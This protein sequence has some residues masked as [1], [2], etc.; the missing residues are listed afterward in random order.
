MNNIEILCKCVEYN[1]LENVQ[2]LLDQG[3]NPTQTAL[4]GRTAIGIACLNKHVEAL[5]IL[6]KACVNYQ[7]SRFDYNTGESE[8]KKWKRHDIDGEHTPEGMDDLQWED[9]IEEPMI[10]TAKVDTVDDEWSVLYRYYARII[11]TTGDLLA[12]AISMRDPHCLDA[13]QESPLHCA[14]SVGSY[15]SVKLLLKHKAPINVT[16]STGYTPLHLAIEQP[17]IVDLLLQYDAN[18]NK[19][20]YVDQMAPIHLA[21]KFEALETI[22]LL[23]AS[24]AQVNITTARGQTALH[25]ATVYEKYESAVILIQCGANVNVQDEEGV[26]PLFT[27]IV[28][29]DYRMAKMLLKNGARLLPSQHL[30]SFTIRNQMREMTHL[31]IQA[32]EN[33]N[34]RDQIGWTPLLLA[35]HKRDITTLEYLIAHGAR[36]NENAY[37]LKELHVAVQQSEST[38]SFRKI[39]RI[40]IRH[41]VE[42]DSLNKW[43]ETPL[44]LAMLMEKY[45][46]AEYL[47]HEGANVNA[48]NFI[49]ARDCMLLVRECNNIN[50]IKLFVNSGLKLIWSELINIVG[51]PNSYTPELHTS[52]QRR[53]NNAEME[54]SSEESCE[55]YLMRV[56]TTPLSLKQ[57]ARIVIRNRIIENMKHHQFIRNF[58]LSDRRY[59]LNNSALES[60]T[61]ALSATETT[62]MNTT[63][64]STENRRTQQQ[65]HSILECLIWQLDLPRILHFY[66]YAFPDLPPLPE[67]FAVFVND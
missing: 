6:L 44:C 59:Q 66:L 3:A 43:G 47:I 65:T 41:G 1:D 22:Q 60:N 4:C 17:Q 18:P 10:G 64:T 27:A 40:L 5:D 21:T 11:E 34:G 46:I 63:I 37:V 52:H 36:I 39:F 14:A 38:D 48:G 24:R 23:K 67:D 35:I 2:K 32:G 62:N 7:P 12:N 45:K 13:Y 55:T 51:N 25:L 9:E 54:D 8:A 30:L 28:V 58:V 19:L 26:T 29:N 61:Q 56:L 53:R 50:L 20:T 33:V 31:L 16:T 42:I 57:L 15:D 49:K